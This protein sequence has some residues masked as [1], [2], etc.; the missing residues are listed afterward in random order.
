MLTRV[1][2]RLF[3]MCNILCPAFLPI[4]KSESNTDK[5]QWKHNQRDLSVRLWIHIPNSQPGMY[6]QKTYSCDSVPLRNISN[7]LKRLQRHDQALPEAQ[8]CIARTYRNSIVHIHQHSSVSAVLQRCNTHSS[9]CTNNSSYYT[10][11]VRLKFSTTH[12]TFC[13][14]SRSN[15]PD[16]LH[17]ISFYTNNSLALS[18]SPFRTSQDTEQQS[19]TSEKGFQRNKG[20]QIQTIVRDRNRRQIRLSRGPHKGTGAQVDPLWMT[21]IWH[22]S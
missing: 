3:N 13:L 4:R 6:A 16:R 12:L 9:A 15:T 8:L 18:Q 21:R 14:L 17:V 19:R 22:Q 7:V 5:I 2:F 1:S 11:S 20:N 10:L